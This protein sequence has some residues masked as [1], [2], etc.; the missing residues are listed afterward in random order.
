[1]KKNTIVYSVLLL[2][3]TSFD[4]ILYIRWIQSMKAYTW[5]ASSIIFPFFGCLFFW[6][7][8]QIK[9]YYQSFQRVPSNDVHLLHI[10]FTEDN[11]LSQKRL[12]LL[13]IFDSANSILGIYATPY[14]SIVIMTIIDKISLPATMIT[15]YF[16]FKRKYQNLHILGAF[17]VVYGVL[18]EFL[19]D[20]I[21]ATNKNGQP[22]E[23]HSPNS[24]WIGIYLLS[25]IPGVA[26]YCFK[27]NY[28][29]TQPKIDIWWMNAWISLWQVVIGFI[30]APIILFSSPHLIGNLTSISQYVSDGIQCQFGGCV[31][32]IWYMLGYQFV[33]TI[34]NILMF[35]LIREESSVIYIMLSTLKMPVTA[36]LGS[37][38]ILVGN[39]AQALGW[40]D[41]FSGIGISI[42]VYLYNIIPER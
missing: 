27:E 4:Y 22:I 38:H 20:F 6:I 10:Q 7:P 18:V 5:L 29:Q 2:L 26:S 25:L 1:M 23:G 16:C 14:L 37:Y 42:G 11:S 39:Q 21:G 24:L 12:L 31:N 8:Y 28:L 40:V 3:T 41:L 34:C 9:K 30:I 13:G 36:W 15:S 17:L 33:S 32:S 19:P 35:L